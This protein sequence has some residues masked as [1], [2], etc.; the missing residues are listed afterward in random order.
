MSSMTTFMRRI[1]SEKPTRRCRPEGWKASECASWYRRIPSSV[2][3][4]CSSST[5]WRYQPR[6]PVQNG[7]TSHGGQYK[8]EVPDAS[9]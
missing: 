2:Q 5:K 1:L 4:G 3:S 9:A 6:R 8:T 7:S